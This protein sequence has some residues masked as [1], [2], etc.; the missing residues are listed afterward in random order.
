MAA[1]HCVLDQGRVAFKYSPEKQVRRTLRVRR[2]KKDGLKRPTGQSCGSHRLCCLAT[3]RGPLERECSLA[4]TGV[5]GAC[6]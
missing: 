4:L 5:T 1:G 3:A 2:A 6:N